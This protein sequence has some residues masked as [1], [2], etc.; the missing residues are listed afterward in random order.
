MILLR[1]M[2][3]HAD[4]L[5][6]FMLLV[7]IIVGWSNAYP[8]PTKRKASIDLNRR[9][10][11]LIRSKS[12]VPATYD[13]YI[14]RRKKSPVH[15]FDTIAVTLLDENRIVSTT[16]FLVS[17]DNRTLAQLTK[18]DLTETPTNQSTVNNRPSRGGPPS[19][20]VTVLVFD[21]LQC[22]FCAQ[23]HANIFPAV[24]N[25]YQGLV[26]V[27][28]LDFPLPQHPW[29]LRAAI[30]AN[31]LAEQNSAAYWDLIDYLHLHAAEIGGND[32]SLGKAFSSLDEQARKQ[33]GGHDLNL[34]RLD[35]CL[36]AQDANSINQSERL[37]ESLGVDRTPTLV[38]NGEIVRQ[39]LTV[40]ELYKVIDRALIASG[41]QAPKHDEIHEMAQ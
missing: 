18:F 33:G 5:K 14:G 9:I 22:P 34:Q 31:C 2:F 39:V 40:P 36:T 26:R 24:L 38:V 25:A 1:A 37:G 29:A 32:N 27:V 35:R 15:G 19:A 6:S 4:R 30:D 23:M 8:K 16:Q 10:E 7:G 11:L 13:L 41:V 20:P 21:D 28:Y 17:R 3:A 12:S